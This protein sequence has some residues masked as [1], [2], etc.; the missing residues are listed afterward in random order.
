MES[1]KAQNFVPVVAFVAAA[2]VLISL[3]SGF[4]FAR[5]DTPLFSFNPYSLFFLIPVLVN[6]SLMV[7]VAHQGYRTTSARWFL[8]FL[9]A[10]VIWGLPQ[11]FFFFTSTESTFLFWNNIVA[12]GWIPVGPLLLAF[13]LSFVGKDRVI[14]NFLYAFLIFGPM[15][16]FLFLYLTTDLIFL[17]DFSLAKLTPWGFLENPVGPLFPIT[18]LWLVGLAVIALFLLIQ[19]YR[20]V[21]YP[22]RKKQTLLLIFGTLI[23][24][25]GGAITDGLLPILGRT[26]F[27]AAVWLTTSMSLII[28]FALIKYGLFVINPA[29]IASTIVQVMGEA[30]I[31]LNPNYVIEFVN[32]KAQEL[33]GYSE[34]NLVGYSVQ[35]FLPDKRSYDRFVGRALSPLFL[36]THST[37]EATEY[38]VETAFSTRVLVSISSSVVRDDRGRPAGIILVL[39]DLRKINTLSEALE[40]ADRDRNSLK[41]T[42]KALLNA[43][44][45]LTEEKQQVE[46]EVAKDTAL[47]ESIGDGMIAVDKDGRVMLV[48]PS[49]EEML[50][51]GSEM[52]GKP[53][54]EVLDLEDKKG[55][56]VPTS[57]RIVPTVLSSGEKLSGTYYFLRKG[58]PKL[59]VAVT[60]APVVSEGDISGV[61][62]VFRDI[63]KETEID[64]SKTE[65]VSLASHELRTPLTSIRWYTEMLLEGDFGK[66]T[67]KKREHLEEIY[68]ENQRMIELVNALLSVSRL[69][70]G[71]FAIEPQPTDLRE[72]VEGEFGELALKI[73]ERKLKV[74]KFY[75]KNLPIVNVD[76]KLTR[77]IFRNLLTNSVK[78]TS[79]G[80]A[81][82]LSLEGGNPDISITVADTGC[83]IPKK[84][85]H[86]IF[87][88]LFRADNV[89]K[90]ETDGTGLGLYMVKSIL[91]EIGGRI[92]FES[93]EGKGTTFHV[94]IPVKG[95][96]KKKGVKGKDI[97]PA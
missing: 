79:E 94:S 39:T 31:V 82:S 38:E 21:R 12:F 72:L 52:I 8:F 89:T 10:I 76:P 22:L 34:S 29:T 33:L 91:D 11:F 54:V 5:I 60:A 3:Y 51:A 45:D 92:R 56:P 41:E 88:K 2:F 68:R 23:P 24:I 37:V 86:L 81:V 69:E 67:G 65:F 74:K 14:S 26:T 42:Q 17:N 70:L 66:I 83:G 59:P 47:L 16:V 84:Q 49:A 48:N 77:I 71:T 1:P 96:P 35:R 9:L 80:G 32:K 64:R 57:K 43:L 20:Q 18:L 61:I 58:L 19:F 62:L 13:S 63:T 15:L 73:K 28:A 90:M 25:V 40:R 85:Q 27:P 6:A 75:S 93:K 50:G 55:N 44:E 4:S 53:F 97:L 46:L 95:M 7:L 30:L 78:Y 87:T 36:D